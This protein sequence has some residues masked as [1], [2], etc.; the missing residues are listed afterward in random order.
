MSL[1]KKAKDR[2]VLGRLEEE[3]FY[4]QAADEM[5]R[6]VRREGLWAK[7]VSQSNG[8]AS[9]VRTKYISLL[10]EALRDE[11]YVAQRVEEMASVPSSAAPLPQTPPESY[12][13]PEAAQAPRGAGAFRKIGFGLMWF[14]ALNLVIGLLI[15]GIAGMIAGAGH[16][17]PQIAYEA[18]RA[19][20]ASVAR[21]K[22]YVFVG[23]AIICIVGTVKGFLPGT[24]KRPQPSARDG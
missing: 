19:A 21:L 2:A 4:A 16:S 20:G 3:A 14:I 11:I 12:T 24:R 23:S 15:G 10:V 22:P 9:V 6:G 13:S 8:N 18:G 7:A 1:W 5:S 17:D